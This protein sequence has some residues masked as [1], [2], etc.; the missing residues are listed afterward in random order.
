MPLYLPTPVKGERLSSVFSPNGTLISA[1]A[2][3]HRVVVLVRLRTSPKRVNHQ[4]YR[5]LKLVRSPTCPG[6][7]EDQTSFQQAAR[8]DV[9]PSDPPLTTRRYGCRQRREKTVWFTTTTKPSVQNVAKEKKN[10]INGAELFNWT[11]WDLM[12]LTERP[13]QNAL[14]EQN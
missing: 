10:W 9:W 3:P 6:A 5:Q 14:T 4:E 7:Q 1:S 12:N 8:Q 13:E 11:E 2:A